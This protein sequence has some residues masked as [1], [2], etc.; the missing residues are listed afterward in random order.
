MENLNYLELNDNASEFE[1]AVKVVTSETFIALYN[2]VRKE[3]NG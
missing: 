2:N 1:N 3:K